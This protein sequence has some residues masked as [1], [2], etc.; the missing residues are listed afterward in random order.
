METQL[1]VPQEWLQHKRQIKMYCFVRK[2]TENN[3]TARFCATLKEW[4]ETGRGLAL[5]TAVFLDQG[6]IPFT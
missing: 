2:K 6:G 4:C 3:R 1:F 5:H